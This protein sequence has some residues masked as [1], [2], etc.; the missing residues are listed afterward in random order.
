MAI[1]DDDDIALLF[2]LGDFAVSATYTPTG[3]G[4]PVVVSVVFNRPKSISGLGP[5][6]SVQTD[7]SVM[8]RATEVATP[9]AGDTYLIDGDTYKHGH[10]TVDDTGKIFHVSLNKQ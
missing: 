7:Y 8:V 6:G 2:D 9:R 1:E 5:I 3:G 10:A 4:S